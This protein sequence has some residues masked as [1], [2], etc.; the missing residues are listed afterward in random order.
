MKVVHICLC[1]PFTDGAGYQENLL[2]KY[3][4]KQGN[5]VTIVAS[6]WEW[7]SKGVLQLN[8]QTGTYTQHGVKIVRLETYYGTINFRFRIFRGLYQT[9]SLEAP[10]V[11]FVHGCQFLDV[12]TIKK[13]LASHPE[14]RAY[15]DNHADFSNSATNKLSLALHRT[16][17]RHC[18]HALIGCVEK[19]YGVLP[20]RVDFLK[21]VYKLP[22]EKC[23]LL[24]MGADDELVEK[25]TSEANKADIRKKY[26]IAPGDFLIMTGGKIDAAKRQTIQ[27]MEAVQCMTESNIRLIVFGSVS[28]DLKEE[29]SRLADGKK[30]QYIGWIEAN[31]AYD[32]FAAADLVVFPGR[33]SVFWEQV[34]GLGVPMLCKYWKGTT[35]IDI[36][37]NV[38][39]LYKDSIEEIKCYISS[40][41]FEGSNEYESMRSA[42]TGL[43]K[44]AFSYKSIADKS[45]STNI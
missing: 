21:E 44:K 36:G 40:L 42:A 9:I 45:L 5:D 39:F 32:H 16:L 8:A 41:A 25:A 6:Q 33:H 30:V 12:Y 35:H 38:K 18:A 4:A 22:A 24:V 3:H 37:G 29:V 31:K 28:E 34:A 15:M 7:N 13:Y 11:L 17:W 14:V 27:L 2:T 26:S 10:D 1:G 20:A 19:A 43:A 23:E